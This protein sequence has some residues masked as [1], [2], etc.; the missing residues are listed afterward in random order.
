M[1][2][3]GVG[4]VGVYVHRARERD[5]EARRVMVRA[6]AAEVGDHA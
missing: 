3:C 5:D 4:V 1:T 6:L 2:M